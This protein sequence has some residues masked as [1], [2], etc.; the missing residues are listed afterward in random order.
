[1]IQ[2]SGPAF[3]VDQRGHGDVD[4]DADQERPGQPGEVL[5]DDRDQQA[6]QRAVVRAPAARRAAAG[7]ASRRKMPTP[8][9]ELVGV[10]GGDAAPAPCRRRR[11]GRRVC[12]SRQRLRPARCPA[13]AGRGRRA[14]SASSSLCVP[15]AV[16]RP[17]CQQRHPVG[18]QHRRR[19]VR[20]DQGRRVGQHVAQRPLDQRLGVHVERRQRVVEDQ[21]RR[22][23]RA[24]RGP[25][26]AAAAARRTATAP[27]RRSGCPGPTAGRARSRP[28]PPAA[29][30]R[31]RR[32]VASGR[33]ERD[34][35]PHAHR[36]Q[37]RRPRTRW[38]PTLRSWASGRSR[39]STPSRVIRPAV[40]S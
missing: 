1:M 5:H 12:A 22:A 39:T 29:P 35:L 31:P 23:G 37:R 4:A 26:P 21:H 36:E 8:V 32:R 30:P 19:P 11:A 3:A 20:D 28:G 40:T 9:G 13:P 14:P 6:P 7:S 2:T 10:L 16:I 25:A 18:Q 15:T 33:P 27:A 38:R 34:V 17:P 24:R